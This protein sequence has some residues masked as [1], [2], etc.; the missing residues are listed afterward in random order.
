MMPYTF[1]VPLPRTAV[2]YSILRDARRSYTRDAAENARE[3]FFKAIRSA[4]K[5][6]ISP[7]R[8]DCWSVHALHR[9]ADGIG[10]CVPKLNKPLERACM[11]EI[12]R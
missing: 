10:V 7:K 12:Q 2:L 11:P 5:R 8:C 9:I 6:V 3:Q 1:Q 4:S